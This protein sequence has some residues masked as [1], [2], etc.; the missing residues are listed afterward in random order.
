MQVVYGD[1]CVDVR[2]VRRWANRCKDGE[3]RKLDLCD[4]QRPVTATNEFHKEQ[5]DEMMKENRWITPNTN[6]EGFEGTRIMICCYMTKIGYIHRVPMWKK[7]ARWIS[8]SS[9]IGRTV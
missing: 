6:C 2:T 3:P 5:V 4:K 8:T 7:L 1:D 9:H